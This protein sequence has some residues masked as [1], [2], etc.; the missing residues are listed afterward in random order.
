[1][2]EKETRILN[3]TDSAQ[4]DLSPQ[5]S[6]P[7]PPSSAL[8]QTDKNQRS[9]LKNLA[10][11]AGLGAAAGA[12]FLGLT[13]MGYSSDDAR[14]D[15]DEINKPEDPANEVTAHEVTV[16]DVP[17]DLNVASSVTD[18]M[19]FEKAFAAARAETG[20]G[21][22]FMWKGGWY[23]TYQA[24]EWATM[25]PDEKATFTEA[26]YNHP[27]HEYTGGGTETPDMPAPNT[28]APNT[29][30]PDTPAPVPNTPTPVPDSPSPDTPMYEQPVPDIPAFDP[31]P[32]HVITGVVV[33][34]GY[35]EDITGATVYM[36]QIDLDGDMI[37]DLS[38]ITNL[39]TGEVIEQPF[40]A[41]DATPDMPFDYNDLASND[42]IPTDDG[43]NWE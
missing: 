38:R 18:D 36:E 24:N 14:S 5:A 32:E 22:Y 41:L 19:S 1:M 29:P 16:N 21:G 33:E 8:D 27:N 43:Y 7:S 20:P 25:T 10:G 6:S 9:T 42:F 30:A 12:L 17:A 37:P 13:S 23:G 31:E 35:G 2:T 28:P 4:N 39:E 40:D 15:D 34:E 3:Q 11:G 26:I